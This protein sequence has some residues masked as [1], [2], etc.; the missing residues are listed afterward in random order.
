MK[1]ISVLKNLLLLHDR[2]E[3][4]EI[5]AFI[6][7]EKSAK[8]DA[9]KN[10]IIPPGKELL[11][12][13]SSPQKDDL[14]KNSIIALGAS[15]E[16]ANKQIT[17]FMKSINDKLNNN[18]DFEIENLGRLKKEGN[19]IVFIEAEN[20]PSLN[21]DALGM[22]KVA[23][24]TDIINK[25][26]ETQEIKPVEKKKRKEKKKEKPT[27]VAIVKKPKE[28]KTVNKA[29][30][31]K[32]MK[33]I[34]FTLPIIALFI[35]I[36]FFH[37]PIIS[38]AKSLF[39]KN[40]TDTTQ[41]VVDNNDIDTTTTF[42]DNTNTNNTNTDDHSDDFG[43]DVEY[44][45]ILDADIPNTAEVYLGNNYKKFY[46]IVNSYKQN[47]YAENYAQQL[48]N[49]GYSP[50]ILNGTEYYRVSLGGYNTAENL[51]EKYH[52]YYDKFNGD[53]WILINKQ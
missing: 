21:I 11:F 6:A 17:E 22:K 35:L 48:R 13:S 18:K 26:K 37:K 45:K 38:Q 36:G 39:A 5:G 20:S 19:K 23:V 24:S 50:E 52:H 47:D 51:I 28:K 4:P 27:K 34:F 15:E 40:T 31:K 7:K 25:I 29:K 53:V 9:N 10:E 42:T 1:T 12:D 41:T 8:I 3:I 16:E 33:A 30:R 2:V 44:R 14:I 43:N 32:T 46:L 49:Q